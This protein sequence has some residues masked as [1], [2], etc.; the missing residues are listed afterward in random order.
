[1]PGWGSDSKRYNEFLLK[2]SQVRHL[3]STENKRIINSKIVMVGDSLIHFFPPDILKEEFPKQEILNRGIGGDTTYL[4]KDRLF[5]T[6]INL[7]PE[8][9]LLQIGGNDLIQGKC[10]SYIEKNYLDIIQI[11]RNALPNTKIIILSVPPTGVPELNAIVPVLNLYLFQFIK[12]DKKIEYID[13][14]GEMRDVDKPIIKMNYSRENDKIH[15]NENGYRVW[16]KLFKPYL[17]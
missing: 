17:K 16:A 3:Y 13:F 14:W 1:M 6:V 8:I 2:W 4:L 12:N 5:D 7:N 9:I 15:F 11:I 10:L